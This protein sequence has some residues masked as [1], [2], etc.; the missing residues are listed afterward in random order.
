MPKDAASHP[1][2]VPVDFS[3]HSEAA[4]LYAC[5]LADCLDQ[6]LLIL[7][8]AHDPAEM[9]GYY[10]RAVKKR[11]KIL[12]RIEDMAGEVLQTFVE[13]MQEEHPRQKALRRAGSL[14][15]VGLPVTR[16]LE[17][18]QLHQAEMVVMGS[19]GRTGLRRVML[20]SK[21]EQ[22]VR[23]CPVPVTIVKVPGETG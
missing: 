18:V 16:I 4:L 17:V 9:P 6:P 21:A 10:A 19:Q 20:G 23:L 1:I 11:K 14:L 12:L 3:P 7:H 8:V 5:R 22:V 2:L 13:R 15:V